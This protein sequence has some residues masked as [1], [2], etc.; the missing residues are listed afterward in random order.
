MATGIG[1]L[2]FENPEKALALILTEL[3]ECPHWP[4][5]P[6]RSS[7][8]HF[9]YQF[10]QPLVACGMVVLRDNRWI[11]DMARDASAEC[12]TDFY[13]TCLPAEEGNPECL[14]S[15]LPSPEAAAGCHAFLS[16]ARSG[17]F[18]R[19]R[20]LKGQIAGPLTVALELK[21]QEGRP[22]YYQG[23]LRDTIVRT[24]ALNARCQAAALSGR[25]YT[26]IIFVDDPA[27]SACGSRLHL[28]LNRET[29]L[30][31]LNFIFTAIRSEGAIPG[32]H[33]CE[34]VDWSLLMESQVQI[35]S[36]DAYRFG[37]SLI[38]YAAQ[39]QAFIERGGGVAWGIVPTLDDPFRES[40]E[41]LLQRLNG[42]W[43]Q[44]FLKGPDRALV[45]RQSMITPACGTGLLTADQAERIYRLTAEVSGLVRK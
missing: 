10:L 41:S 25:G 12:L 36:L 6:R 16:R 38:P 22:A 4:Q 14:R 45:V 33:S 37:A 28:A 9:V 34:A 26:P 8:E 30:E 15:F 7:R 35:L 23:D 13:T 19:A 43:D 27:I 44:L 29:I 31:D 18:A 21:D 2:P 3:P 42:L 32:V 1:S 17:E 24:L 20:Y 40:G 5:L 11:F 39:L